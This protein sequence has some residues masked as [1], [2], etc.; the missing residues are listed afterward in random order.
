MIVEEMLPNIESFS[1][2]MTESIINFYI[3]E[4]SYIPEFEKSQLEYEGLIR[5]FEPRIDING[6]RI[7]Q[8]YDTENN[9]II[10]SE[11]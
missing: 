2:Y 4:D 3:E 11:N 8:P 7:V 9:N 1:D 10:V 5:F 6:K